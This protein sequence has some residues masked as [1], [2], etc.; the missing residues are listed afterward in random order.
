[1]HIL[2]RDVQELEQLVVEIG[3]DGHFDKLDMEL[4]HTRIKGVLHMLEVASEMII[5]P[6]EVREASVHQPTPPVPVEDK[7]R[8]S[9]LPTGSVQS[10]LFPPELFQAAAPLHAEPE[11]SKVEQTPVVPKT[12]PE[13]PSPAETLHRQKEEP[14]HD[15]QILGEKFT[16][17]KSVNDLLMEEKGKSDLRFSLP[18]TSLASAIGTNDRFLFTRE[19]FDG[20]MDRFYETIHKLDTMPSIREAVDFLQE[21]FQWKKSETSNKL[22]ELVK[23]RF[24]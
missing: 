4:L 17:G 1:M 3:Q 24:Q 23:R 21:N 12:A 22:L 16:A 2:L 18:I 5:Q 6:A 8:P 10:P 11:I 13:K 14:H 19:L 15:K 7:P 9:G 20:N